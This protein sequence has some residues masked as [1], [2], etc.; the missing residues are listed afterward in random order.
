MGRRPRDSSIGQSRRLRRLFASDASWVGRTSRG[1]VGWRKIKAAAI[2]DPEYAAFSRNSAGTLPKCR[3]SASQVSQRTVYP[4]RMGSCSCGSR[5]TVV[6]EHHVD[7]DS[8]G[9]PEAVV[10]KLGG[11]RRNDYSERDG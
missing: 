6:P 8:P 3:V 4:S 2:S 10:P 5:G 1:K 7:G 9:C 11:G